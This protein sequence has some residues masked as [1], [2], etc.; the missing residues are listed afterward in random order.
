MMRRRM[1][2][3]L[4]AIAAAVTLTVAVPGSAYA[5]EGVLI[6]NGNAYEDPSGCYPVDWFP[7]S[8][9]NHTDAIAEVHS[10][11]GCGGPVERLVHPGETYY[12]ETAQSV[13]IL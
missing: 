9:T 12:T 13:F 7:S 4:G 2:V 11:P 8:V 1:A 10:G 3:T 6:V 5:A